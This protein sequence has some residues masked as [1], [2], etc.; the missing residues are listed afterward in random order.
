M[1][2]SVHALAQPAALAKGGDAGQVAQD[3]ASAGRLRM[4]S[5]RLAKLYVQAGMGLKSGAARQQIDATI[6]EVDAE[7]GRLARYAK[8]ANIQRNQARSEAL[9]QEMRVALK[10]TPDAAA[11]ERVNQIADELMV[12]AGKLAMQIEGESETPVG[13]LLDLSTRLNM[14][15]QRLARL[16]LQAYAGNRTQGVLVDIEQARKEFAGGLQELDAAR[17]NSSASREAIGLARNQWIF[18]DGAISDLGKGGRRE[19]KSAQ[20]VATSSERIAQVLDQT[21]LQYVRDYADG[22]RNSR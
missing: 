6:V 9:W 22:L 15:S 14:L 11:S 4:Q 21:S 12:H 10:K 3:I 8:K 17:K 13:R 18:F 5:Q 7:F 1:G 19:D 2:P 16:Y 20:N